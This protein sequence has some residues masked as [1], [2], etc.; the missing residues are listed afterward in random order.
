MDLN[1][2]LYLL[3]FLAIMNT[4]KREFHFCFTLIYMVYIK[5]GFKILVIPIV[6]S[7]VM[8]LIYRL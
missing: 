3:G 4:E 1:I 8:D 6:N 7:T 2:R 5:V